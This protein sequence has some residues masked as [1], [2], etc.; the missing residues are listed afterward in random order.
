[1]SWSVS[2]FGSPSGVSS[3][4][5]EISEMLTDQSKEEFDEAKPNLQGLL[6][7]VVG[8]NT[9]VRLVASG[10]ASFTDGEKTNGNITVDLSTFY[11]EWCD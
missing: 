8:N 5:D 9:N 6:S 10:H 2:L 3:K 7:Q 4:L 1:M 11:G